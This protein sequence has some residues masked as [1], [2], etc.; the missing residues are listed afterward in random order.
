[1][2]KRRIW[3]VTE[4]FYPEETAVAYIFTRIAH[5]FS[6]SYNVSVICGP[7]Y[8]DKSKRS[9]VDAIEISKEIEIHRVKSF[10]LDKNSILQ[11]AFKV[12]FLSIQMGWSMFRRISK[13][14]TVILATN[15]APLLL[16]AGIIKSHKRFQLHVLVHDVFPENSVPAKIVK[17]QNS[18]SFKCLKYL[19]DKS[20]SRADH[21]IVIGSDMKEIISSKIKRFNNDLPVSIVTNW[22]N[23]ENK[24]LPYNRI[25]NKVDKKEIILQY[26]GNLGRVQ[27]LIEIIEAFRK[28]NNSDLI[29]KIQGTGVLYSYIENYLKTYRISNIELGGSY[30]RTEEAGILSNC[31]IGIVSLSFGMYGLGVP[32]KSYHLLSA[33]KP[34]L[35]VGEQGTEI[36]RMVIDNE[37]GWSLDIKEHDDLVKFFTS[38]SLIDKDI[39]SDMGAKARALAINKYNEPIILEQFQSAVEAFKVINKG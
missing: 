31:D 4:L 37:I 14:D 22:S 34:I 19:F 13:E 28:S 9:F 17:S 5:H 1:M 2:I 27:G 20:Y 21:L 7:E 11:R 6:K 29:L 3:I 10:N 32:S 38:L 25:I 36:S 16:L 35:Y 8:Y 18:F 15:P 39:I 33:G 24:P 23:P 12:L 26:A 30:S